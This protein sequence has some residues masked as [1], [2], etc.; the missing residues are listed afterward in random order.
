MPT[1][2]IFREW[3]VPLAT[4]LQ[5]LC[6]FRFNLRVA[7]VGKNIKGLAETIVPAI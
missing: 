2:K 4:V 3:S 1:F 6:N 5:Y 7:K